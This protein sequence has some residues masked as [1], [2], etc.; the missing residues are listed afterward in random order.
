MIKINVKYFLLLL[1][2]ITLFYF[3][4][5]FSNTNLNLGGINFW[6]K[7]H[8]YLNSKDDS[9]SIYVVTKNGVFLKFHKYNVRNNETIKIS[10]PINSKFIISLPASGTVAYKWSIDNQDNLNLLK[11]EDEEYTICSINKLNLSNKDGD[12]STRK[13][14]YFQTQSVGT[15]KINLIYSHI[16]NP[17][18]LPKFNISLDI[19]IE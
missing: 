11:L 2:I 7:Q 10:I 1:V 17:D 4:Q 14:Y 5:V 3:V 13:F 9:R 15:N 19:L 6:S 16:E 18:K 12:D 8:K